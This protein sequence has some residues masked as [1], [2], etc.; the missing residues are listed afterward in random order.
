MSW[1][2]TSRSFI[3]GIKISISPGGM[4]DWV[5]EIWPKMTWRWSSLMR[6]WSDRSKN[7]KMR[8]QLFDTRR[9]NRFLS[10]H[11]IMSCLC[12]HFRSFSIIFWIILAGW[13]IPSTTVPQPNMDPKW[14]KIWSGSWGIAP[15]VPKMVSCIQ[16]GY[17]RQWQHFL[18]SH[19]IMSWLCG[20]KFVIFGTFLDNPGWMRDLA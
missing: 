15:I 19:F 5:L 4:R 11:I 9:V 1:L 2:H 7:D 14:S 17:T 8:G 3:F 13:G 6:Y 10:F 20:H 12:G 16:L 18:E